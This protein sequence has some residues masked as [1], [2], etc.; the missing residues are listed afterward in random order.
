MQISD[1]S[2][3]CEINMIGNL[4]YSSTHNFK[5]NTVPSGPLKGMSKVNDGIMLKRAFIVSGFFSGHI[6]GYVGSHITSDK[7]CSL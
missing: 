7:P 1:C 4:K 2:V 6:F 5:H 3:W